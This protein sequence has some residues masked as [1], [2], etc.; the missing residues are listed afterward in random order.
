M[1]RSWYTRG[2][3]RGLDAAAAA[4]LLALLS[5]VL[6]V[7]AVVVR[8]RLGS[9]VLFRQARAGRAE[10]PFTMLKFRTMTDARSADGHL[11]PDG[12]RLTETGRALRRT[13]LDE[14]PELWNVLRGDMSLIGPRPLPLHYLPFFRPEERAR[15][16]VRPG[17]TGLAQV[18]GRNRATWDE[19]FSLDV[20]YVRTC[21]LATDARILWRTVRVALSR[22][23]LVEDPESVMANLDDERRSELRGP[24]GTAAS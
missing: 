24:D 12:E 22:D 6:G 5:P 13:S 9:P 19:R 11:L 15:F 4:I 16:D 3:K 14:L 10:R 20:V 18:S 17:I 7:V 1:N 8:R 2:A 21:S 23:G